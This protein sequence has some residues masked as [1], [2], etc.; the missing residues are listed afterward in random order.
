MQLGLAGIQGSAWSRSYHDSVVPGEYCQL[1]EPSNQI[2]P[3]CDIA[4]YEDR[5]SEDR[6]WVHESPA[7]AVTSP[8]CCGKNGGGADSRRV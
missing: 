8:W 7:T 4:S 6:E 3:R 2:P 5:K 1:I